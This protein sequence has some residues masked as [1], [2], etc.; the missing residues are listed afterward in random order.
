ME[1]RTISQGVQIGYTLPSEIRLSP[2]LLD[3]PEN[4]ENLVV[5]PD[6]VFMKLVKPGWIA[7]T[8]CYVIRCVMLPLL[9]LSSFWNSF[10]S[11]MFWMS[12][13]NGF[14]LQ[15]LFKLRSESLQ[16]ERDNP[17]WTAYHSVYSIMYR[18]LLFVLKSIVSVQYLKFFGYLLTWR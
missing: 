6:T 2:I 3:L 12:R 15:L 1:W 4:T 11:Y 14:I 18:V 17:I 10:L 16:W 7:L 8:L 5:S 9:L 13:F